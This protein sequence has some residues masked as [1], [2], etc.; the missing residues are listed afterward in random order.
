MTS[1][2]EPRGYCPVCKKEVNLERE[3][4][5]LWIVILLLIFT[6]GIGLIFYYFLRERRRCGYCGSYCQS[7]L[8]N[9]RSAQEN[10]EITR[11][12]GIFCKFCG[13]E[14]NRENQEFCPSCGT[15]S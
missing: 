2:Y 3:R 9:G 5:E 12:K 13:T 10:G 7:T 11:V 1:P 14:L 8:Y 4:M 6:G 15:K